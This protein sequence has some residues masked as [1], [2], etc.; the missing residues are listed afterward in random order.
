M[1]I[2]IVTNSP[3]DW[4]TQIENVQVIDARSY[5]TDPAYCEMKGIKLFNL[6]RSYRYQTTGYYV[7]LLAE[8]RGHR[9][10]PSI[11]TVQDLKNQAIVRIV[12]D[13]L[14]EMIQSCLS[15]IKSDKFTL[16]VY[17][18]HNMARRYDRLALQLFNQFQA[19][20]MR[21]HFV[22]L[23]NG[24]QLRRIAAISANE[25]PE[26]HWPFV[27]NMATEHFAKKRGGV[28]R[29]SRTRFDLAI[30]HNPQD[31]EPPS[32]AKALKKFMKAAESLGM[33]AELIE[34]D[35]YGRLAEFDALFIRDTTAVDNYT[36]RFSRR[37]VGEG[38]VVIDDPVSIVR[39]TNKVYLAEL[40]SR[41]KVPRPK[42]IVVHRDNSLAVAAE[43]GLP[44]VLKRPDS[45]FSQGVVKVDTK[46]E[47]AEKLEAFFAKSDLIVAQEFLPTTFD[48][49]I[50]VIDKYP[51]YACKYYMAAGH[52]QIIDQARQG[53]GRY[54][55]SETLPIEM[56][57]RKAV[58]A[59]L[60]AA[61]LIGDGF[62]GVDVK[63]SDG[64]FYVIEVNDNP[65]A[66][67][68]VEDAILRDDLYLRIMN[69]FLSRIE[70]RKARSY[71]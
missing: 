60:K 32:D 68:G 41:H 58:Q 53:R 18:G 54:G 29:R 1:P 10:L 9:P 49:R 34:R 15:R 44:L 8:A 69:V 33:S 66:D 16:S 20:L 27:I 45:S 6:C 52:W 57:P 59:A 51:L 13:E 30:L 14:D 65:N 19:P 46:E 43:L 26:T 50:G 31:P 12:S 4:P 55:R 61:N 71:T 64:G 48:W 28:R 40:L 42:T 22:R 38:L 62:Y 39:C 70:Q 7:S 67:A 36:Y 21:A 23:E 56:A 2:L 17:F 35:D 5:L 11:T 37:A 63:Q 3:K 47:L 25:V 24:W